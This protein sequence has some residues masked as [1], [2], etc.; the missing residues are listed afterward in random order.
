M[1]FKTNNKFYWIIGKIF[2]RHS[3]SSCLLDNSWAL[4]KPLKSE[5]KNECVKGMSANSM[6]EMSINQIAMHLSEISLASIISRY[7]IIHILYYLICLFKYLNLYDMIGYTVWSLGD[8]KHLCIYVCLNIFWT[9]KKLYFFKP[10][11][12]NDP[13][14]HSMEKKAR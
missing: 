13:Y 8:C 10:L 6:N 7:W 3:H 14:I 4:H 9:L 12:V 5:H 2:S 11:F 1:A